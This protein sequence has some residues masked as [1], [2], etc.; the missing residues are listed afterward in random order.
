M[1]CIETLCISLTVLE[2]IASGIHVVMSAE[3]KIHVKLI[4]HLLKSRVHIIL[5][6]RIRR[7]F[8]DCLRRFVM[9]YDQP[10]ILARILGNRRIHGHPE[11]LHHCLCLGIVL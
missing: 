4:H 7:M 3:D 11:V 1:E 9:R 2:H 5:N 10:V 6:I 8:C